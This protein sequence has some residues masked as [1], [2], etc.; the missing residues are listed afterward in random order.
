MQR[1]F[2][3][4]FVTGGA[5]YCGSLLVPQLLSHG[6][7]VTV[8]DTL[9]FGDDFFPKANPNLSIVRGDIRDRARIAQ[10]VSGHD[11]F[12]S[13][14]CISNDASFEL[15]EKLSTSINMEAFEP[16]VAAAKAAGVKRFV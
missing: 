6:Y 8:Y 13:L 9:M 10:A 15:D 16:M 7:K 12:V 2:S 14:A 11:A 4:V 5:G 3:S 1:L